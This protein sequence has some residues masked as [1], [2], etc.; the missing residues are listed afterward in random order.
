MPKRNR[1]IWKG[2]VAYANANLETE[3]E[4]FASFAD[5]LLDCMP[6][7]AR[8]ATFGLIPILAR[9]YKTNPTRQIEGLFRAG[10]VQFQPEIRRLLSWLC[11]PE[12]NKQDRP[13]AF[14][15]LQEH[16]E[17]ARFTSE[18][19]VFDEGHPENPRYWTPRG[20]LRDDFPHRSLNYEDI[21]D[22]VCDFILNEHE[23][24]HDELYQMARKGKSLGLVPIVLCASGC[25]RFIMPERT[26]RKTYC[27]TECYSKKY[28]ADKPSDFKK[29]YQC[30]WRL[31]DD[32]KKNSEFYSEN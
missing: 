4:S 21:A 19:P 12:L 6:W 9:D 27:S 16:M 7:L 26:G 8:N 14:D 13:F 31:E 1:Q 29:C 24:Y 10:A 5:T 32:K 2:L 22:P 3:V 15:F 17:H 30:L 18:E 20:E 28:R 25:G 23:R 11:N